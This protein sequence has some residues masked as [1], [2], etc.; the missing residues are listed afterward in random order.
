MACVDAF[1]N[2][3]DHA[4]TNLLEVADAGQLG[5]GVFATAAIP[6]YTLLGEYLGELVPSDGMVA[7]GDAYIFTLE[8]E[9][10]ISKSPIAVPYQDLPPRAPWVKHRW[11]VSTQPRGPNVAHIT[12]Y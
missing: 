1:H 6:K 2:Q 10:I 11:K 9:F 12:T 3:A 4:Q 5:K 7:A 8:G